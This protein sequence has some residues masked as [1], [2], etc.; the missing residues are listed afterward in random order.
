MTSF[1]VDWTMVYV[2]GHFACRVSSMRIVRV[3][4]RIARIMVANVQQ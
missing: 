1:I 3:R 2:K 4:T